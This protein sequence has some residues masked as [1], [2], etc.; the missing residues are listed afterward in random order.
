MEV[1]AQPSTK[2]DGNQPVNHQSAS[3]V[4]FLLNLAVLFA[5]TFQPGPLV[6]EFVGHVFCQPS[7]VVMIR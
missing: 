2:M 5:Q 4:N 6:G 3:V 7:Q 1:T